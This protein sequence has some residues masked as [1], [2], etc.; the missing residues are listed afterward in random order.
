M[1]VG[2][3]RICAWPDTKASRDVQSPPRPSP[4]Q[5]MNPRGGWEAVFLIWGHAK[6][7]GQQRDPAPVTPDPSKAADLLPC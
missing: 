7:C 4:P 5:R 3:G 2:G 1:Y 6:G